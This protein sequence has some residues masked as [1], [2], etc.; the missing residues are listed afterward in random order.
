MQYA[1]IIHDEPGYLDVLSEE[2]HEAECRALAEDPRY[3][4]GAQLQPVETATSVR[5]AGGRTLVT[6]GRSP[7]PRKCSPGCCGTRRRRTACWR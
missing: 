5:V 3:V 7:T 6:D 4:G 2:D 1:L